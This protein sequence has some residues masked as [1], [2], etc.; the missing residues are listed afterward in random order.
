MAGPKAAKAAVSE[1]LANRLPAHLVARRNAFNINAEQLPDPRQYL[2]YE[3]ILLDAWPSIITLVQDTR[4]ITREDWDLA[5]NP[6]YGVV[7]S[8]R[9]YAWASGIGGQRATEMRDDLATAVREVLLDHPG[10]DDATCKHM[11]DEGTIREEFSD[12]TMLKGDR[13]MAGA[14]VAFD[15]K[16]QESVERDALGIVELTGVTLELDLI[17]PVP[18]APTRV[19]V[20][21]AGPASYAVNITWNESTWEGGKVP[22]TGYQVQQSF[23]AGTNWGIAIADTGSRNGSASVSGLIGGETY[24]F[25][26]AGINSEGIG[27]LSASSNEVTIT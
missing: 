11:V 25:R 10:I 4:R 12:L 3:P 1:F 8:M 2:T 7:Y 6:E 5:D 24:V 19:R 22:L 9:T 18:N 26:V 13:I 23:D 17:E 21:S 14:F 16:V 20:G 27:A 15:L